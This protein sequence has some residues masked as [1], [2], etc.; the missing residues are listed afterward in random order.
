[1]WRHIASNFLTFLVVLVF[2]AGGVIL[3]GQTKYTSAGPLEQSIC[4][5]VERG[6]NMRVVS[7][8][9]SE[10]GAITSAP[11]FRL[12]ADYSDKARQLKAGSW[13]IPEGTS[14][15]DTIDIITRGGAS[16]SVC[17]DLPRPKL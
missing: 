12:G 7:E 4:L 16:I 10:R 1:M 6:S 17:P 14:M 15:K 9:L 11:L 3:W 5:R 2:L 13:L 8:D